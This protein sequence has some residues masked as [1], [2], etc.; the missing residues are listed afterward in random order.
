MNFIS[1]AQNY[2]DVML[3][4]ALKHVE[5]GFYVDVGAN[6]PVEDSTT[7]AFYDRGWRGINIEPVTGWYKN[8]ILDR[9]R[10]INLQVA[11]GD[12]NGELR[13]FEVV[14]TGLS[15]TNEDY[16]KK[17]AKEQGYDVYELT[18]PVQTLSTILHEHNVFDIHFLKI[19]VEG[20][21][22]SVLKG[23]DLATIRPWVILI[24]ATKPQTTILDFDRWEGLITEQNYQF[25]YFDGLNRFYVAHEHSEL[26]AFFAAPPNPWD[27]YER[28]S[29]YKDRENVRSLEAQLREQELT[30]RTLETS[31]R[32]LETSFRELETSFKKMLSSRSMK[33]TA[34]LRAGLNVARKIKNLPKSLPRKLVKVVVEQPRLRRI[35]K[36]I[37]NRFPSVQYRLS[38]FLHKDNKP[39]WTNLSQLNDTDLS[40]RSARILQDLRRVV[41]KSR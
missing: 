16:A 39:S 33:I 10:D 27:R 3:W 36:P 9:P 19:D 24:E 2:E 4:R 7:K 13:L 18:V 25:V 28:F 29:A 14:S 8:L 41:P 31:F 32:E 15:T 21:E 30:T 35:V 17:H 34:P 23:L 1:Y 37:A 11:A 38:Y 5:S 20:S 22:Q 26:A 6:D 12:Y 40:T